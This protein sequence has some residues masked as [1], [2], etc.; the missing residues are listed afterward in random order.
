M[1]C[2]TSSCLRVGRPLLYAG[3]HHVHDHRFKITMDV[4]R[5]GIAGQRRGGVK[6][7]VTPRQDI[8]SVRMF[9]FLIA[10]EGPFVIHYGIGQMTVENHSLYESVPPWG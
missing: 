5:S 7:G 2:E 1:V 9:T 3:S 4:G 6:V 8:L 10:P